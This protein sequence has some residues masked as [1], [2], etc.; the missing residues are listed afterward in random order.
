VKSPSSSDGIGSALGTTSLGE[1]FGTAVGAAGDGT[2]AEGGAVGE[3]AGLE[4]VQP[5]MTTRT[6]T[7]A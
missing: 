4:A 5:A 2:S 6:M 1:A 7:M 3:A